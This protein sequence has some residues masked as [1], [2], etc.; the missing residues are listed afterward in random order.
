[1]KKS[2]L[3]A[4]IAL[5]MA[6]TTAGCSK[7]DDALADGEQPDVETPTE[8]E[9]PEEPQKPNPI[10]YL[11]PIRTETGFLRFAPSRDFAA[12]CTGHC[13]TFLAQ[14]VRAVLT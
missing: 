5:M 3:W 10:D 7:E 14:G 6:L 12:H 8:P 2:S 9:K 1:M 13:S 4:A 11:L